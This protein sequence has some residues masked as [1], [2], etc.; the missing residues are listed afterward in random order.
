[1]TKPTIWIAA[2]GTGGHIY[3]ALA[4]AKTMTDA[5]W[6]VHWVG[7]S[8]GLEA[9]LC[10]ERGI[11]FWSIPNLK[12]RGF[13]HVFVW[14]KHFV[15][16]FWCLKKIRAVVPADIILCMGGYVTM[17]TGMMAVLTRT[18]LFIHEQNTVLGRTNRLLYPFIRSGFCAFPG[19]AKRYPALYQVGNPH[20]LPLQMHK[21]TFP[22]T[23]PFKILSFGG[24]QGAKQ[25]N[26]LLAKIMVDQRL[27]HCHFWHIA[28]H[29]DQ[30]MLAL[31]DQR[32][33]VTTYLDDMKQAYEWA[34]MV[35]VRSGAMTLTEVSVYGLPAL[36]LP[37]QYA[38]DNHQ[39]KN[40]AFYIE[41][42]AALWCAKRS[43]AL[44]EQILSLSQDQS[45][46]DVLAENMYRLAP[47]ASTSEL[48]MQHM[49]AVLMASNYCEKKR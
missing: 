25:L 41:R 39:Q 36:L 38:K 5:G 35:I 15:Q 2:G 10:H 27:E 11:Q 40:A 26:T 18:A 29:Q 33:K 22:S 16:A 8:N 30:A 49:D 24:S 32:I 37:Y 9:R 31:N 46:Y 21:R 14:L 28:G 45:A 13:K 3:P 7:C 44:V 6:V 20:T 17:P 47:R 34:D 1:M 23:K 42:G 43:G 19:V 4:V 12:W 48:M